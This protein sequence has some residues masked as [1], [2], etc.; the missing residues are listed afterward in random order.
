MTKWVEVEV[1]M[2]RR[3]VVEVPH[4]ASEFPEQWAD[5]EVFNNAL[6]SKEQKSVPSIETYVVD[7][8]EYLE[9]IKQV[10]EVIKL[11]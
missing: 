10:A 11:V 8:L 6:T 5:S 7:D 1:T 3:F 2:H 9:H 4:H